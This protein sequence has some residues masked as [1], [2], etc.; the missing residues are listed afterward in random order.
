MYF[1]YVQLQVQTEW[2]QLQLY[3]LNYRNFCFK[4]MYAVCFRLLLILQ[5]KCQQ[6]LYDPSA[7][8][9]TVHSRA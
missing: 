2:P 9:A 6:I 7:A 3:I 1:K 4:S 5:R 8:S